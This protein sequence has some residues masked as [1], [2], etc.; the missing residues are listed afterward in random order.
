MIDIKNHAS[1][2]HESGAKP[3]FK[4]NQS[5]VVTRNGTSHVLLKRLLI[6]SLCIIYSIFGES[7]L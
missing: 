6:G 7:N 2:F 5:P 3:K 1:R 4:V